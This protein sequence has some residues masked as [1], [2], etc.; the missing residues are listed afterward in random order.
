MKI[1]KIISEITEEEKTP[2][3]LQL[4]EIIQL[5]SEEN[6][7]LKD[8]IARLKGNNPKP[9]IKP[10]GLGGENKKRRI[11]PDK[12]RPGS[13]KKNKTKN[14]TIHN[15][16]IVK[17]ETTLPE[18]SKFKGY[19]DWFVQDIVFEAS[20]TVYRLERWKTPDGSYVTAKL[21]AELSGSHFGPTLKTFILCQN[22]HGHVTQPLILEQLNEI[23]IAISSGQI[24]RILTED[25]DIF[26]EEKEN[27]LKVGLEVSDY[28]N[29]DDT[30]ARH[31]GRN[32]YCTHIGNEFFAYFEST[33]SKS[34]INFLTILRAGFEDYVIN[35]SA[36]SYMAKHKLPQKTLQELASQLASVFENEEAWNN[37]LKELGIT[38]PR[39][40]QIATEGALIG[41][42]MEHDFNRNLVIIS[43]DAGQFNVFLHGLCWIHAERSINKLVGFNEEQCAA[44]EEKQNQIWEFYQ[45]LKGYKECQS[46]DKKKYLESR[47]DEIFTEKT[48]FATLNKAL[49]RIYKNKSELL[50]VLERPEIPLHNNLS[51]S[52]IREYAK[53][54]KISGSTRSSPGRKCRDTFTSLKKTC[55]KLGISFWEYLKDRLKGSNTVPYLPDLIRIR[56]RESSV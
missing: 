50:L 24:N 6:Q 13:D 28:V 5:Q 14:I 11:N 25:K 34:R 9:K 52:D 3:V 18:G 27:I 12:K 56:A 43:D 44:L 15:E 30:G 37:N 8:E 16:K 35:S 31:Q 20:N 10:S 55:R 17:P 33:E 36:L 51:E 49:E 53:R 26:H 42:I 48:C 21:P 22:N 38:S 1:G 2:L 7:K 40:I 45:E 47:F 4:L 54:R 46:E 29:V 41:S 23:G 39:H 32:G 19:Q